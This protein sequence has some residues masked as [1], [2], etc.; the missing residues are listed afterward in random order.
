[1]YRVIEDPIFNENAYE[2]SAGKTLVYPPK[3]Q[4]TEI[5]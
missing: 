2:F 1:M 3:L 5:A 4:N